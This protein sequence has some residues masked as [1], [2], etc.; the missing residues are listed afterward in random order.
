MASKPLSEPIM[1]WHYNDVILS[2]MASQITSDPVVC[3]IVGSGA[4]QRKH[5]GSASLAFMRGI[6]RW[7]VNSPHKRPVT[8]KVFPFDDVFMDHLGVYGSL[9]LTELKPT[10]R[11]FHKVFCPQYTHFMTILICSLSSLSICGLPVRIWYSYRMLQIYIIIQKHH[12]FDMAHQIT[13]LRNCNLA[14]IAASSYVI[15]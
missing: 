9:G 13:P 6:H 11:K 5:E 12:W 3:S 2:A 1:I 8:W 7:P 15:E 10:T 4:D 14:T